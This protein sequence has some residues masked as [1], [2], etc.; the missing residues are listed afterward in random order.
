MT[1]SLIQSNQIAISQE[2]YMDL[3]NDLSL[4]LKVP[5]TRFDYCL[6]LYLVYFKYNWHH[7]YPTK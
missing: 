3:S 4:S 7:T 2:L 5:Y 6:H 1:T